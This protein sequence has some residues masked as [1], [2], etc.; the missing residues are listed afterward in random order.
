MELHNGHH[1][2]C[3]DLG[4]AANWLKTCL[5]LCANFMLT[6]VSTS[7]CKS[8]QVHT[9]LGHTNLQVA[10]VFDLHPF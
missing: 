2:T 7:H 9:R 6:K 8:M 10:Q 5:D 4:W 3:I 1:S